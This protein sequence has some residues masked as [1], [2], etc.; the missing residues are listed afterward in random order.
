MKTGLLSYHFGAVTG[1]HKR[2]VNL[3]AEDLDR[4]NFIYAFGGIFS[5]AVYSGAG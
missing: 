2:E 5:G 4:D 3:E 1:V